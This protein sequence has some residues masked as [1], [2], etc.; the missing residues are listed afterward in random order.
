MTKLL[1]A[2]DR[3]RQSVAKDG[4]AVLPNVW[5][6]APLNFPAFDAMVLKHI[7]THKHKLDNLR[8]F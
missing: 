7:A 3:G 5:M 8:S 2:Y 6:H 4:L 1:C